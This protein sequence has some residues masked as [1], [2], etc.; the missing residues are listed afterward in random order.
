VTRVTLAMTRAE[1]EE[2]LAGVHVGVLSVDDPGHGPLTV[3]IWYAYRPGGTVDVVT[4]G[5]SIKARCLRT[6]GRFSLCAQDETPPYSY[7]SV[8]GPIT[9]SGDTV[10][11]DERR[12]M[13]YRYLGPEF[14]DLYLAATEVDAA[15]SVVFRMTPERWLTTDFAK[16]FG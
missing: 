10:S 12:A 11:A 4:G 5:Q 1:R 13:A 15:D 2:F 3:P 6:A 16:Q 8:E 9:A 7:V 14:G